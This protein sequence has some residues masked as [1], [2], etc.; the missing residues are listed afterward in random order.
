MIKVNRLSKSFGAQCAVDQ[1]SMHIAEGEFYGLLGPNGAGKTTTISVLSTLLAPDEGEI[2][3]AGFELHSNKA[4]IRRHIGVVPQE[5]AL[6]EDLSAE[7]NLL[8]FGALHGLCKSEQ[9]KR[10]GEL[11]DWMGLTD[12]KH[13][14]VKTYS[15][16]MKRRIN[17]AIAL[18]HNPDILFLDEPTVGIDPQSKHRVFEVLERLREQKKTI[19]YTTHYMRDA[20]QFCDRIGIMDGGKLLAEGSMQDLVNSSGVSGKEVVIQTA[21][22]T[23][24]QRD[25]IKTHW[26]QSSTEENAIRL[27][28]SETKS[29]L[30]AVMT[31]LEEHRVDVHQIEFGTVPLE[32]I[33][34]QLTGKKLRD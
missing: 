12:R 10:A 8:F 32:T 7:R 15:G 26:P 4:Q 16:G 2:R 31:F 23:E 27:V 28:S 6:Y 19:V 9:V 21:Y 14:A 18:M 13:H 25:K 11:I 22:L 1:L 33:F 20:E 17:L 34:L 5:I 30:I 29:E 24:Q 3:I